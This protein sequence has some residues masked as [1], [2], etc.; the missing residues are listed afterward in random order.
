M[1][2]HDHEEADIM[3]PLHVVDVVRG[4]KLRTIDVWSPDTDVLVLLID[5]AA[6]GPIERFF[7]NVYCERSDLVTLPALRWKLFRKKNLEGEKLLPT[8]GTLQPHIVRTNYMSMRDKSYISVMAKLPPLEQNGSEVR[9]D[10]RYPPIKCLNKPAPEAV[11]LLPE[12]WPLLD[13]IV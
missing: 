7:C 10:E 13:S 5:L 12:K 2:T 1:T 4:S 3:I 8:R 9:S 11:L 6:N